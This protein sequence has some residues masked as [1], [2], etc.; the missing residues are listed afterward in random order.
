MPRPP[1][2]CQALERVTGARGLPGAAFPGF[3][4]PPL[5]E[6]REDVPVLVRYFLDR[7]GSQLRKRITDVPPKVM[8]ALRSYDWPGNVRELESVLEHAMIVSPGST[9]VLGEH[10]SSGP[11]AALSK[12][13]LLD[14]VERAHILE[15]LAEC[16]GRVKG[17]NNAA[18]RLGLKAS[19][20]RDRMKRLGIELPSR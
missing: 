13:E 15:V 2:I 18:E 10:L 17:V 3:R 12:S 20:L 6:R 8:N 14:D 9:L 5:R 4:V 11:P 1:G 16:G 7:K 19:T